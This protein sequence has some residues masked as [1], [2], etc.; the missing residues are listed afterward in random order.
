M[1]T[2]FIGFMGSGKTTLG[3]R[4]GA[5]MHRPVADLDQLVALQGNRTI[6]EIF[7]DEHEAGFRAREWEALLSLPPQDDLILSSGGGIVENPR[8]V[9]ALRER[10]TVFWLDLPWRAAWARLR[11]TAAERPLVAELGEQGLRSL[12]IRRRPLYAAASDFRL[13]SD[14]LDPDRLGRAVVTA[15]LS[16]HGTEFRT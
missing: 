11:G 3:N 10:G 14:R 9:A 7:R 13:R 8:A 12:F 6:P 15:D 5:I 16:W 1:W 4:L 2:I